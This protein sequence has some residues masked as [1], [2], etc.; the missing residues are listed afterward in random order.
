MRPGKNS[1]LL[2]IASV[3]LVSVAASTNA[4][5]IAPGQTAIALFENNPSGGAT[6]VATQT[7]PFATSN[8]TGFLVSTVLSNDTTNPFGG[9]TFTYQ[10]SNDAPSANSLARLTVNGFT[11][12]TTDMSYLLGSGTVAPTTNDRD[13]SGG[14]VGF[15]FL[16]QP[17]GLGT[18]AAGTSSELL[19]VQTNS[20]S[21]LT[22][23]ANVSNGAVSPVNA[24]G[25]NGAVTPEPTT[26][27][28]L[29]AGSLLF[30]RRR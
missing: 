16:G 28:A 7:Q 10:L 14:V 2:A 9:L 1:A 3:A 12:Y 20:S 23:I 4:A 29:A 19:V 21:F 8:Y 15:S 24:Y 11:G 26:L 30:R 17:V 27:A 22:R 13:G 18:L 6:V 25:P 5:V